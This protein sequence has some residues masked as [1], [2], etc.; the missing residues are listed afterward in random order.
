[1]LQYTEATL[2]TLCVPW[3]CLP[4]HSHWVSDA[5]PVPQGLRS[6][7][8]AILKLFLNVRKTRICFTQDYKN[9]NVSI[10]IFVSKSEPEWEPYSGH[11]ITL[12][13]IFLLVK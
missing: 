3:N 2:D 5:Y 4:P 9:S 1:M 12:Y 6:A 13:K 10:P 7:C 11:L 8:E